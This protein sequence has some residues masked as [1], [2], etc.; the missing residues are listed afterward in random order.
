MTHQGNAAVHQHPPAVEYSRTR[1]SIPARGT[2]HPYGGRAANGCAVSA[3]TDAI[4]AH[5]FSIPGANCQYCSG[6]GTPLPYNGW[7]S[8][9]IAVNEKAA[10]DPPGR[11]GCR[12]AAHTKQIAQHRP[13]RT[14]I[15]I[16]DTEH[17]KPPPVDSSREDWTDDI[18]SVAVLQPHEFPF[19]LLNG[20]LPLISGFVPG[21]PSKSATDREK[22]LVL[23]TKVVFW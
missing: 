20:T 8:R 13:D 5:H 22:T 9:Y 4:G 23:R 17:G 2:P 21:Y 18:R 6:R 3:A 1:R 10:G 19:S 11:C 15:E 16:T 14:A 7:C 12:S